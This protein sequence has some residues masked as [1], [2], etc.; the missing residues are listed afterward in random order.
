MDEIVVRCRLKQFEVV[1]IEVGLNI[2][3]W[4]PIS[5]ELFVVL[6]LG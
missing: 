2:L 3:N 1:V 4:V 5:D 6:K